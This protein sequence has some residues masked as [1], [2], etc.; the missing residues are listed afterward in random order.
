MI[1]VFIV[2]IVTTDSLNTW[3]GSIQPNINWTQSWTIVVL[4]H[5]LSMRTSSELWSSWFTWTT[6]GLDFSV[7]TYRSKSVTTKTNHFLRIQTAL[8]SLQWEPNKRTQAGVEE[9]RR[10]GVQVDVLHVD[11]DVRVWAPRHADTHQ[12]VL[13]LGHYHHLKHPQGVGKGEVEMLQQRRRFQAFNIAM[14]PVSF[15]FFQSE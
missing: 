9:P 5:L 15:Y 11:W 12:R 3:N 2:V 4:C 1:P 13:L 8:F 14:L 7:N 10:A 6:S